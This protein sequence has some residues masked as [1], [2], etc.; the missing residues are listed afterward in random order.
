MS[1]TIVFL[2]ANATGTTYEAIQKA[3]AWGCRI[4][5]VTMERPFYAGLADNPVELADEVIECDTY[6]PVAILRA[7]AGVQADAIISFDDYHLPVAALC[8]MSLGLPHPDVGSLIAARYKDFTRQRLA[9]VPGAVRSQR[10]TESALREADLAALDYPLVV[11]PVDESGSVSVRLCRGPRDVVEALAQFGR[12]QVNLRGYKPVRALLLEEYV[13]GEEYSCELLWDREREGWKVVGITKKI[14]AP[15][16]YFVEAGHVFPADL[17]SELAQRIEQ[18]VLSWLAALGLRCAAAHVEL[19]VQDGEPRL[20][21][22]NPRLA[23]DF[24]TKLVY[25]STGVDMVEH[26]LAFH[27]RSRRAV[28][29]QPIRHAAAAIRFFLTSEVCSAERAR[30]LEDCMTELP[31]LIAHKLK[32]PAGAI[33]RTTQ[34]NYDRVGYALLGAP[35]IPVLRASIDAIDELLKTPTFSEEI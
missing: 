18:R 29:P 23:G 27:M 20:I 3:Q 13:E 19:R 14:L 10:F 21:E 8:A 33:D 15:P 26:Y 31:E 24:I 28:P 4:V 17:P 22:I 11:K 25:W 1:S 9:G 35:S 5:F 30:Q 34:S 2:E 12:H 6:D 16:P 7:I 32:I